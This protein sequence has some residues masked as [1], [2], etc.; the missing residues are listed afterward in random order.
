MGIAPPPLG[1]PAAADPPDADPDDPDALEPPEAPGEAGLP[2]EC[3][4]DAG[5]QPDLATVPDGRARA[6]RGSS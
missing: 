2:G 6:G 1:T 5:P 3:A 4:T